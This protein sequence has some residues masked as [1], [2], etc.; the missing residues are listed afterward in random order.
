[1]SV[2]L[3][4]PR[5]RSKI[6]SFIS[7]IK[8]PIT[9]AYIL[10]FILLVSAVLAGYFSKKTKMHIGRN[11]SKVRE[12][13]NI[14]Q[15]QLAVSLKVSQQTVS[16]IEQTPQISEQVIERV[17]KALDVPPQLIRDFDEALFIK[18][19]QSS[20]GQEQLQGALS[21]AK[22]FEKIVELY[23]RLLISERK[24]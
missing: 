14:K 23:E 8:K 5:N 11:I 9:I 19:F 17:A 18:F 13:M 20:L 24:K 22:L 3:P 4:Y 16:K 15:E 1:M 12:L 6:K 21:T 7:E 2:I 10:Q